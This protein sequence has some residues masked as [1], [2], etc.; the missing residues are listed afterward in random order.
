[1][2]IIKKGSY[3][4]LFSGENLQLQRGGNGRWKITTS[5]SS[6]VEKGFVEVRE[7][8]YI[9][10]LPPESLHIYSGYKRRMYC[11][12]KGYKYS[13]E[14]VFDDLAVLY[15]EE[16]NTRKALGLHI[17]DDSRLKVCYEDFIA[18]SSLIWEEREAIKGFRF[19]VPLYVFL[20]KNGEYV[21][22]WTVEDRDI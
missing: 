21:S 9:L 19:D 22:G 5:D 6:F 15:P 11:I 16:K 10:Y 3:R 4:I 20:Y 1:M 13:V 18:S 8:I 14:T 7:G 2:R 12:Y 17:Y